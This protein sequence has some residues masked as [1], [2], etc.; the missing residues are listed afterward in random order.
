MFGNGRCIHWEEPNRPMRFGPEIV[1]LS[2]VRLI[3]RI[4]KEEET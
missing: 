4:Y 2:V 1:R 3:C